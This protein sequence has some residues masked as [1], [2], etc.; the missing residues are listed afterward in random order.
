MKLKKDMQ[1]T[2]KERVMLMTK[3]IWKT[4]IETLHA[5]TAS[6]TAALLLPLGYLNVGRMQNGN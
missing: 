4:C 3:K 5:V 6:I 1:I 2:K